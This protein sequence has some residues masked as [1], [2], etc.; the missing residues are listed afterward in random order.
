MPGGEQDW[1]DFGKSPKHTWSQNHHWEG[2]GEGGFIKYAIFKTCK[3]SLE[4]IQGIPMSPI[5]FKK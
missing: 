3:N 1:S 4:I 5:Q 2:K